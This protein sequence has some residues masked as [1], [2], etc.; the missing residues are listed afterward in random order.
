M[1]F[2]SVRRFAGNLDATIA[3]VSRRVMFMLETATV[4][5]QRTLRLLDAVERSKSVSSCETCVIM[6]NA[7]ASE[8]LS[9]TIRAIKL[10]HRVHDLTVKEARE[11]NVIVTT[12]VSQLNTHVQGSVCAELRLSAR[13]P[14]GVRS[15]LSNCLVMSC[16]DKIRGFHRSILSLRYHVSCLMASV[17]IETNDI[18][19]NGGGE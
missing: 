1:V 13:I 6:A 16:F 14:V 8:A 11:F 10:V 9:L 4:H 19:E 3:S 15:D 12:I 7:Y 17:C 2:I 18:D 5:E